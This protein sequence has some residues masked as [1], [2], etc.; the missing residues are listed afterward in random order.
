MTAV[1]A[2]CLFI[3]ALFFAPLP[4]YATAPAIVFVACIMAGGLADIDCKDV[5]E[6]A[7]GVITALSMPLTI[8]PS[9][10]VSGWASSAMSP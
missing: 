6:Y 9:R 4:P 8:F 3:L 2:A 5:T 10:R 1:S 7:P